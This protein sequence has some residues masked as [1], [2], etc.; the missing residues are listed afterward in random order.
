MDIDIV[1]DINRYR[2]RYNLAGVA[3][4]SSC[5]GLRCSPGSYGDPGMRGIEP[6]EAERHIFEAKADAD[7]HRREAR[8]GRATRRVADG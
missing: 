1:T 2:Y 4:A 7:M 8:D 5:T 3:G 6:C